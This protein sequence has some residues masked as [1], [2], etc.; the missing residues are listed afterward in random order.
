MLRNRELANRALPRRRIGHLRAWV[1]ILSLGLL[2]TGSVFCSK[3]HEAPV[4]FH[5]T[6]LGTPTQLQAELQA[7][8]RVV[9]TWT[10]EDISNVSGYV[11]SLYDTTGLLR[12]SLVAET[13]HTIEESSLTADGFVD[14]TW[15]SF[16][17]CAL[18]SA[19]FR[20]S[21]AQLDTV[22]VF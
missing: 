4:A 12:E 8:Q 22:L 17:V 6:L 18:D 21:A 7:R 16:R 13:T 19:L 20:G 5:Q 10:M 11:V 3:E 15:F 9:L 2:L 1:G 14:S